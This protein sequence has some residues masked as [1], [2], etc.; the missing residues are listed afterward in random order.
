MQPQASGPPQRPA[1]WV[2][3]EAGDWVSVAFTVTADALSYRG[4]V[5]EAVSVPFAQIA[6]VDELVSA[7]PGTSQLELRT[8]GGVTVGAIIA[9]SK[10]GPLVAALR[11]RPAVAAPPLSAAP[12]RTTLVGGGN[13]STGFG[14]SPAPMMTMQPVRS[15]GRR[16][17]LIAGG[18]A[19]AVLLIGGVLWFRAGGSAPT[20]LPPSSTTMVGTYVLYDE[21]G[22]IEGSVTD[23]EGTG[24]YSDF[25]EGQ[26]LTV[27]D[28]QGTIIGAGQVRHPTDVTDLQN[29]STA[30]ERDTFAQVWDKL[31]DDSSF[32][33][34]LVFD[35]EVKDA[36]FYELTLGRRGTQTW[37]RAELEAQDFRVSV[38]LGDA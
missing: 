28:G 35:V 1:E 20:V 29:H 36:D 32:G 27:R 24:G 10:V 31:S 25:T 22:D 14:S 3:I 2:R 38:S 13:S 34:V 4:M 16:N 12:T 33:C 9:S 19:A 5:G 8:S 21:S 23:C 11:A 18:V 6:G 37:T 26:D 17:A 15:S 30:D 7:T